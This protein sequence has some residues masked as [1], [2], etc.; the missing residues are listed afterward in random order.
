MNLQRKSVWLESARTAV[1]AIVCVSLAAP[2]AFAEAMPARDVPAPRV[3]QPLTQQQKVLHALNRFTFGP[4]PGDE[5]AVAKMGA[6]AWFERQLHPEKIDDTGLEGRLEAFPA[7]HLSQADLIRRFPSPAVI[8]QM[9]R[10]GDPLP[11]DPVEHA[12]YADAIAAYE[13]KA[14][15]QPAD[16]Q[17]AQ[18]GATMA[19]DENMQAEAGEAMQTPDQA[20]ITPA[21]PARAKGKRKLDVPRASPDEVQAVLA[22][23]PDQRL[24]RLI[25]MQ[26]EEMLSFRAALKPFQR[27]AMLRGLTP[28]QVEIAAALQGGPLRV[29]GAEALESRLVRDVYSERQ[30]QAV[31][32]D[33]W[34]NH[35]SV[36]ARKNQNEPYYLA[37]YE[38]DT[39][40]PNALGKFEDILVATA[41]SPA[42]LM[43]LDNWQSIGPDSLAATRVKRMGN[44]APKLAKAIPKGLNENYAREL[45][46]LHTLGVNG[47]YT[48]KDVI[49]VAKCFTGW[50]IDRP[51]QGGGFRFEPNR[52]EGGS[53]VV[54]GKTIPEGGMNEGLTVLHMLATSPATAKFIST[55]LAVRFVSDTPP[56]ALIDRMSATFLKTDGDIKAVLTTMYRS[57]EFNSPTVYRAKLKT[58]IE[59]MASALRASD[60]AVNNPL[61]LV[62][63]ME[64]L[65]MPIYGM[66]TPN[67][68]SWLAEPWASS[69][70]LVSR[71]N[72]AV[73]L[74]GSRI[75]GTRTDWSQLV[76]EPNSAATPA[77]EHKL[78]NLILGQP[79]AERTR[80]TVLQQANNP[81]L[82]KT[83]Q[84]SFALKPSDDSDPDVGAAVLKRKRPGKG[85]GA[86]VFDSV[87]ANEPEAPLD[88]MAGLLLGSPDFQR[89]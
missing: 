89:R 20:A 83:A 77:T 45:M 63:A 28:E 29:I 48:Q 25:A 87:R 37:S 88:T 49:E 76:G 21:S 35:F 52:H 14:K 7:L 79:A 73:V 44:F 17:L 54:L 23:P 62:Q 30:V 13:A 5:Q 33:F 85:A 50:T 31:M 86:G 27:V 56:P 12:I 65:G 68:Y 10:R 51:Y 84:Q 9:S 34:L 59:F 58:P 32:T 53:K 1:V 38:N 18:K 8:R 3:T 39:I 69:N 22:L 36:Y 55:K 82:Q 15:N 60:A 11:S 19:A 64:Q 6:E 24:A 66:Q 80:N 81:D 2:Q 41:Q 72:F 43:Y 26:P 40:L 57:P 71:M 61:P 78:E 75:P 67:G 70:A 42:M 16:S 4:R 47:G 74:S 46:E